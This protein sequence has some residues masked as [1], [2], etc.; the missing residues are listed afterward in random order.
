[1]L[2]RN[3][4]LYVVTVLAVGSPQAHGCAP[5]LADSPR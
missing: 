1:M 2:Q 3:I 4:S 5:A